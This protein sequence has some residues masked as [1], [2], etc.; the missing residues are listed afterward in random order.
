M[1]K[2]TIFVLLANVVALVMLASMLIEPSDAQGGVSS[3]STIRIS[4]F[5]RAQPRTS[6]AVTNGGTINA[7]GTFQRIHSAG[8]VGTAGTA[9]TVKPAG[10]LLTLVNIGANQ[11]TITETGVFTS[12]G[13]IVLGAGDSAT[14]YS[15]GAAW[16]QVGA[17]NN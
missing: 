12:A 14:L 13:N 6:I 15:N 17:S 9:I 2:R 4:N 11:I 7:T 10:T 5:Y 8:T 3:F 16:T 1:S